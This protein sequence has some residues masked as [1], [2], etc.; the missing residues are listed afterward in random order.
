M[1]YM[2][3]ANY[4]GNHFFPMLVHKFIFS[5]NLFKCILK[6]FS[7]VTI[8]AWVTES[9]TN[10]LDSKK[11]LFFKDSLRNISL[12]ELYIKSIPENFI[13]KIYITSY[14]LKFLF[15]R[16]QKTQNTIQVKCLWDMYKFYHLQG[17]LFY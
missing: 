13:A 8:L 7:F 12:F 14:L 16:G 17:N 11:N 1:K 3:K 15:I 10:K 9:Y 2:K 4:G 5:T 6:L